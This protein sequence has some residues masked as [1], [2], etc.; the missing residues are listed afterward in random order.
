MPN[1]PSPTLSDIPSK[2]RRKL[3]KLLFERDVLGYAFSYAK[4]FRLI[5]SLGNYSDEDIHASLQD[6]IL[7]FDT[8]QEDEAKKDLNDRI[9]AILT[10]HGLKGLRSPDPFGRLMDLSMYESTSAPRFNRDKAVEIAP[11]LGVSTTKILEILERATSP[12][13]TFAAVKVQAVRQKSDE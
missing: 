5:E 8:P 2:E 4:L 10:E 3:E 7:A 12:G 11:S 6:C 9:S 1:V 13:K